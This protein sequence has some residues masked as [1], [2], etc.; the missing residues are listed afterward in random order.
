MGLMHLLNGKSHFQLV[1]HISIHIILVCE[2]CHDHTP[3][4]RRNYTSME[5]A[6]TLKH[7]VDLST[8][9]FSL[10]WENESV[11]TTF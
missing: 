9:K 3:F 1:F 6:Y 5:A 2:E 11:T 4:I 10:C 8:Y 7:F